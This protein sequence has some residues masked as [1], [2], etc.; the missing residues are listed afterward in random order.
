MR[1]R[2]LWLFRITAVLLPVVALTALELV[3]QLFA[4]PDD[5]RLNI[6]AVA[7]FS[8]YREDGEQYFYISQKHI[9]NGTDIKIRVRKPQNTV[10]IFVLGESASAGWPHPPEETFSAYLQH[11]LRVAWAA[12]GVEVINASAHGFAAY[13]IRYILHEV[14]RMQPDAIILWTG[15][16][17]FLEERNYETAHSRVAALADRLQTVRLVRSACGV[18]R[19]TALPGNDLHNLAEAFWKKAKREALR[20]RSDPE[21]FAL[22]KQHYAESLKAMVQ[23]TDARGVPLVAFTVPV[24]L[25]DWLPTV[26]HHTLPEHARTQWQQWYHRGRRPLVRNTCV[27]DGIVAMQ[28]AIQRDLKHAESHYWL[29]RLHEAAEHPDEAT[30]AYHRAVDLDYNPFRAI[31]AFNESVRLTVRA[32]ALARLLDMEVI[33]AAE[34]D[35][36]APGFDLFLDYVHPTKRGNLIVARHAYDLLFRVLTEAPP[37]TPFTPPPSPGTPRY[38]E[39]RDMELLRIIFDMC[40]RNHQY[41]G[42]I[43]VTQRIAQAAFGRPIRGPDDPI[44]DHIPRHFSRGYRAFVAYQELERRIVLGEPVTGAEKEQVQRMLDEYYAAEFPFGVI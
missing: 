33:F 41:E 30:A 26:S 13:R 39:A 40:G 16:N 10:R 28:Q 42:A 31:S 43:R 37:P 32:S 11:A 25:R 34:S 6:A 3:L 38:D 1:R 29:A 15:N 35:H 17:E 7:A 8:K 44:L 12:K 9:F 24:N 4:A 18:D 22:V 19:R 2:R 14:V 36:G 5:P 27:A 23:E 20:L 21:Q